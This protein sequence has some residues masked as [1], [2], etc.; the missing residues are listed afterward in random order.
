M[1]KKPIKKAEKEEE[2]DEENLHLKG[3][4][5]ELRN[6]KITLKKVQKL[7]EMAREALN[8]YASE[9]QLHKGNTFG[10]KIIQK[11]SFLASNVDKAEENG[12]S[13]PVIRNVRLNI[14]DKRVQDLIDKKILLDDEIERE[15]HPD[16]KK[17]QAIFEEQ[18]IE[19]E[20]ALSYAFSISDE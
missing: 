11:L 2:L 7:E 20:F 12:I 14:S 8:S 16:L 15:E 3:L 10:I 13:I 18:H 4:C 19:G 9:K 6:A 1:A 17:L 5:E